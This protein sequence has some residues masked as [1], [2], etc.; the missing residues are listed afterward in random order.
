MKNPPLH[1]E[2]IALAELLKDIRTS[3]G[4]SQQ[5]LAESMNWRQTDISKVERCARQIG[6]IELRHWMV[7]LGT[8]TVA[9]EIE[10]E[11]RLRALGI[12]APSPKGGRRQKKQLLR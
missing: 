3:A 4:L 8:D 11:E 10:F 7:A 5:Q 6:Y 9:L 2:Q 12:P 1:P